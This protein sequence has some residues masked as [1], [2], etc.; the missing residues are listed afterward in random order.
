MGFGIWR[1]RFGVSWNIYDDGGSLMLLGA[2]VLW[3]EEVFA[4]VA[5]ILGVSLAIG[6][7]VG[8]RN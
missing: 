4:F 3:H 7:D 6:F 1:L 2:D 5:T 8:S